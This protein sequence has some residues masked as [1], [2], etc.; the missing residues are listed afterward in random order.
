MA[1]F[2]ADP[3]RVSISVRRFTDRFWRVLIQSRVTGH[4][5]ATTATGPRKAL[6]RALRMAESSNLVPGIDLDMQW[7]FEHPQKPGPT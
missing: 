5:C 1:R 4:V 6:A 2:R 7:A 3:A